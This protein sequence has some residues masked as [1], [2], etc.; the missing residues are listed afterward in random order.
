MKN[1]VL[2]MHCHFYDHSWSA[3][4]NDYNQHWRFPHGP[5]FS[6]R[7]FDMDEVENMDKMTHFREFEYYVFFQHNDMII[8]AP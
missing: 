1:G 6:V 5:Y 2:N 7:R 4:N 8:F 3:Q